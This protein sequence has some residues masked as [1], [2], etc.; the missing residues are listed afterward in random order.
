MPARYALQAVEKRRLKVTDLDDTND[1]FE[2]LPMRF[3]HP[4][5]ESFSELRSWVAEGIGLVCFSN[6]FCDPS[7]WGHYAD[8]YKGICLGFD[9]IPYTYDEQISNR[10][11]QVTYV[12]DRVDIRE[13]DTQF[14]DGRLDIRNLDL[15]KV[16]KIL[17]FKSRHWEYE[18]EWRIFHRKIKPD[19][20][21]GLHFWPFGNQTKLC[22][23]L[24]GYRCSE[25]NIESRLEELVASY[26]DSPKIFCTRRSL[27]TFQIEKVT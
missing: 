13:F 18:K 21:T 25:S 12:Q 8:R 7:L 20:D 2:Y 11:R 16:I 10:A 3:N 23:I 22:E 24:I 9:I 19:P 5:D 27:S 1:A 14:V 6:A 4:E 15:P 17:T 26:P